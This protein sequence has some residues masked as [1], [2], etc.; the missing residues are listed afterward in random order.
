MNIRNINK[1]EFNGVSVP[2]RLCI[3]VEREGKTVDGY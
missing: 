1:K 2:V 3:E